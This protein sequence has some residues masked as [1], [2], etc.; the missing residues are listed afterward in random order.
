MAPLKGVRLLSALQLAGR[1]PDDCHGVT[2]SGDIDGVAQINY[3]CYLNSD[4]LKIIACLG[5]GDEVVC[6]E[7]GPPLPPPPEN[8]D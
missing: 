6:N 8:I 4:I 2:I 3:R 5:V 7:D 1:L